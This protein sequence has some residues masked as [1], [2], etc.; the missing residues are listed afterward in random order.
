MESDR[1]HIAELMKRQCRVV[2]SHC[3]WL[4]VAV[5]APEAQPDQF[6]LFIQRDYWKAIEPTTYPLEVPSLGVVVEVAI[7]IAGLARL[8][9][10]EVMILPG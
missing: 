10:R 8:L 4:V 1:Q 5:A 3:L 9:C 6:I 7:A 2:G